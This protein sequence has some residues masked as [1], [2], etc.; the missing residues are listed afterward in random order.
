V[1]ATGRRHHL[2]RRSGQPASFE[3]GGACNTVLPPAGRGLVVE[4]GGE[5]GLGSEPHQCRCHRRPFAPGTGPVDGE[6]DKV[7]ITCRAQYVTR[8]DRSGT[9]RR[10]DKGTAADLAGDQAASLGLG[11]GAAYRADRDAQLPGQIAVCRVPA[12]RRPFRLGRC[13]GC[14]NSIVNRRSAI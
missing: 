13:R 7:G 9:A 8:H 6:V 11:I 1:L 12:A 5:I 10:P 3:K 2:L 14:A 4:Q